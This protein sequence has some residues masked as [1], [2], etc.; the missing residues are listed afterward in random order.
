MNWDLRVFFIGGYLSYKALF[1]WMHPSHYIPTMLGA[2]VFQVLF[3][4]YVGRFAELQDDTFF[5][6]GNAVQ[7]T[8]MAGVYG[9][10]GH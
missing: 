1:N 3:F 2:P 8:A 10:A 6:T 9:M 5:V 4:V 7:L